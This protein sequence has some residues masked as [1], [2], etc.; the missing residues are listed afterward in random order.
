MYIFIHVTM[1]ICS[2]MITKQIHKMY[3]NILIKLSYMVPH[4]FSSVRRRVFQCS[5]ISYV[6]F[7][8]YQHVSMLLQICYT[9]PFILGCRKSS[10]GRIETTQKLFEMTRQIYF[11]QT[12][13]QILENTHIFVFGLRR[14]NNFILYS[15][16]NMHINTSP[17]VFIF[18]FIYF[19]YCF[20]LYIIYFINK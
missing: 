9:N 10:C 11:Y 15:I 13:E 4:S 2:Y 8:N 16:S 18:I 20:C 19:C 17:Y 1:F 5:D 3:I 12:T 7:N 14:R 6:E